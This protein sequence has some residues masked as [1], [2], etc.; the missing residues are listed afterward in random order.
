M[1]LLNFS[2]KGRDSRSDYLLSQVSAVAL[3]VVFAGAATALRT[4]AASLAGPAA[5]VLYVIS[6][7]PV[8]VIAWLVVASV[9][10]RLHDLG[11]AGAAAAFVLVPGINVLVWLLLAVWPGIV[12]LN[13][14]GKD[15][16]IVVKPADAAPWQPVEPDAPGKHSPA[17]KRLR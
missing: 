3:A 4:A 11:Y 14:F 12:G 2:A 9:V 7:L 16:R 1:K 8:P 15:P 5:D 13:R 6:V 17:V 10:R